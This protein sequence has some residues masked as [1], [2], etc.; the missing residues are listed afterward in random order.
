MS[1]IAIIIL[2]FNEEHNIPS[3]IENVRQIDADIYVVDSFSTD[4]TM[5]LLKE[6]DSYCPESI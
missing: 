5:D 2:T 4:K 1:K 6:R 3:I